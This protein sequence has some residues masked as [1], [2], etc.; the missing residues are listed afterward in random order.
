MTETPKPKKDER[1]QKGASKVQPQ[2]F[3]SIASKM[4]D[5]FIVKD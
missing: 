5:W 3:Q 2:R 4:K 1:T